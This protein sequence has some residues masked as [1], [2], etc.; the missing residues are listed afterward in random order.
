MTRWLPESWQHAA[1]RLRDDIQRVIEHWW[2]RQEPRDAPRELEVVDT[3]RTSLSPWSSFVGAPALDVEED[4]DEVVVTVDLPGVE[5]EDYTV[6]VSGTRLLI[7]GEKK[8][9]TERRGSGYYYAER[10]YG[11]FTRVIPLPCDV[12]AEKAE[13]RYKNG[14]LRVT[15]PKTAQAK[16]RRVHV[17]IN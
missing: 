7:R 12:E 16:D 6:E 13:A 1:E 17:K 15:L 2:H 11:A 10:S 14:V 8:H 5:R 3:P 4:D 9:A